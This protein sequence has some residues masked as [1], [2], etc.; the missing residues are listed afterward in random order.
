MLYKTI[1]GIWN[2]IPVNGFFCKFLNKKIAYSMA[3]IHLETFISSS[4]DHTIII[5]H[6]Y[7]RY[8]PCR[9]N[10]VIF[11]KISFCGVFYKFLNRKI[12][13]SELW[14]RQEGFMW[15][16]KHHTNTWQPKYDRHQSPE[17]E[18]PYFIFLSFS[19]DF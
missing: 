13:D 15:L 11:N 2:H 19:L 5:E 14:D 12:A 1:N 7:C 16:P 10:V 18:I 6:Q 3:P 9:T 4:N 8:E 17:V